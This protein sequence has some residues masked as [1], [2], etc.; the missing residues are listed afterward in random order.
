MQRSPILRG[1]I[2]RGIIGEILGRS[3]QVAHSC[4]LDVRSDALRGGSH[5]PPPTALRSYLLPVDD[6]LD[7][8]QRLGIDVCYLHE[9]WKLGRKEHVDD[10]GAVHYIDGLI[11]GR[12]DLKQVIPPDLGPVRRRIEEFLEASSGTGLGWAYALASPGDIVTA[13]GYQ[14]YSTAIYDDPGFIDEFL[15][16]YEEFSLP[17]TELVLS[18]DP[19]AVVLASGVCFKSGLA[20]RMEHAERFVL[21][22]LAK[23]IAPISARGIPAI[24]HSDGNN[25]PVLDRWIELGFVGIHPCEPCDGFDIYTMKRRW[26]EKITLLGN[27]DI[28]GVL[29]RGTP[30]EVAQDT[31][32][33]L[34]R[35]SVG[36]GYIC[37]SSHNVDQSAPIANLTA[38]V[39]TVCGFRVATNI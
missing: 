1:G 34:Q 23:Q 8:A 21:S 30:E 13:I 22:R 18:Y 11:K 36:S 31:L 37:G 14:D 19:D 10:S 12:S 20:M 35:L 33:H 27:I 5:P 6:Y 29:G 9:P 7:L 4:R 32:T 25:N 26:G 16:R 39:E 17:L 28:A 15:N 2:H 38:M 24:I 3:V